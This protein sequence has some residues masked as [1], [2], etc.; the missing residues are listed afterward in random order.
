MF[1]LL[2]WCLGGG[3]IFIEKQIESASFILHP[4]MVAGL[5]HV[6]CKCPSLFILQMRE[7][8]IWAAISFMLYV[9]AAIVSVPKVANS[10]GW[11]G[12]VVFFAIFFD[13][14]LVSVIPITFP[15]YSSRIGFLKRP[16]PEDGAAEKD[17]PAKKKP[18]RVS[19]GCGCPAHA[20]YRPG[21]RPHFC[22]GAGGNCGAVGVQVSPGY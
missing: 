4:C 13:T 9:V 2:S 11:P 1:F 12:W 15:A 7:A 21:A 6:R 18:G 8:L 14:L 3:E 10:L 20:H 22:V 19:S 17:E 16:A 5:D